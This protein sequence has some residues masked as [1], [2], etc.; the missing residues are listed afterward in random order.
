MLQE[1]YDPHQLRW[2]YMRKVEVWLWLECGSSW[3]ATQQFQTITR[4]PGSGPLTKITAEIEAIVEQQMLIDDETTAVQLQKILN[5]RRHSLS[6]QTILRSRSRLGWTFRGSTYC[7]LLLD[8]N[9]LKQ[10]EW[11]R[12]HLSSQQYVPRVR[13]FNFFMAATVHN[14]RTL[15]TLLLTGTFVCVQMYMYVYV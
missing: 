1:A 13:Y 4:W 3:S 15:C 7:Q 14:V 5:D 6:L 10:L 8:A 12:E 11:A 9:K 2:R